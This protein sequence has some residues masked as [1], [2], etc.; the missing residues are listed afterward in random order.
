MMPVARARTKQF[1][2]SGTTR[3]ATFTAQA[4]RSVEGRLPAARIRIGR[5]IA[6]AMRLT[7]AKVNVHIAARIAIRGATARR[8]SARSDRLSAKNLAVRLVIGSPFC[9]LYQSPFLKRA[10]QIDKF[11]AASI[12]FD[13]V[14]LQ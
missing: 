14:S 8:T 2:P 7:R 4:I 12:G 10:E 13:V 3:L 6:S 1:P 5:L 11:P 9:D